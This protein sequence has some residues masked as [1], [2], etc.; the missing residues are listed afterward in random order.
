MTSPDGY[1]QT[2]TDSLTCPHF[3]DH[4]IKMTS[5]D[6]YIKPDNKQMKNP[7]EAG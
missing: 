2:A 6:A 5:P 1:R 7:A 4:P 3:S